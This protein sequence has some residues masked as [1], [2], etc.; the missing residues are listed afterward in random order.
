MQVGQWVNAGQTLAR[1]VEPGRLKAVLRIPETQAKD[2]V[3]G[4]AAKIDTRNGI[5]QGSVM[6]IDP[7]RA[8]RYGGRRRRARRRLP[9]GARPDLSV[10]GTIEI[11]QPQQRSLC[12]PPGLSAS[13]RARS[14]CSSSSRQATTRCAVNVKLGRSSVNFIEIVEQ[15][16]KEGDV[17][18][19]SDMSAY[20]S[21]E[22]VR[23]KK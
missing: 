1:V 22:R 19:L 10:D 21:F 12:W 14:V 2:V 23:V 20:D 8:E 13:R 9:A 4:Q 3:I 5:I 17:V 16:L 15:G 11:E 7:G 18:I 6:R